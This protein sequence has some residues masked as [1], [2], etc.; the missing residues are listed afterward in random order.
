MVETR[1]ERFWKADGQE[2]GLIDKIKSKQ[3][4]SGLPSIEKTASEH[5]IITLLQWILLKVHNDKLEEPDYEL[6]QVEA[7]DESGEKVNF[8]TSSE[9]FIQGITEMCGDIPT[10]V[11][12]VVTQI[13]SAPSKNYK[14]RKFYRPRIVDIV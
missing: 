10:P 12:G 3:S 9:T 5:E 2:L 11:G 7:V 6:L 8:N 14:D 1:V 4:I 13:V